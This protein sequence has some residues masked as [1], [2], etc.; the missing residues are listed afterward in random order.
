[1]TGKVQRGGK[2]V[3]SLKLPRNWQKAPLSLLADVQTGIAKGKRV[4]GSPISLPYLR[5]ANVQDGYVDLSVEA[6]S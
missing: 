5:V 2:G 6:V 4:K 3:R 1:M